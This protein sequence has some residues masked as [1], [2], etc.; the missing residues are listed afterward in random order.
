MTV[1]NF[2]TIASLL[3]FDDPDDF[4]FVQIL[5]RTKDAATKGNNRLIRHYPIYSHDQLEKHRPE[6]ITLC[7][8]FNARAY[9]HLNRRSARQV[10]LEMLTDLAENIRT[11]NVVHLHR[12]HSTACGRHHSAKDKTW[13][14]DVDHDKNVDITKLAADLAELQ[15]VGDKVVAT[16]RTKNGLHLI[17]RPFN[18]QRFGELYRH[19]DVHK[20]NPTVLYV[21]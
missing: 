21:P 20:N 6:M 15:P 4:Y 9:I 17:T 19:L 12:I 5:Q 14:V 18:S 2:P 7:E 1:D 16:I 11:G 8:T 13:V 10:A 3:R